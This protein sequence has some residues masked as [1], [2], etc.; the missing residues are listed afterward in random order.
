MRSHVNAANLITTGSIAAAF[1]AL[2]L[3]SDGR[4]GAALIAVAVAAVLDSIDG[5]IARRTSSGGPFGG[6]LDLIADHAAFAVAPAFMLHQATLH[7]VPLGGAAAC[8]VFVLAG[9]WAPR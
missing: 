4:L 8:L 3:A 2:L 7:E 6:Q 1:A 9:A 5:P